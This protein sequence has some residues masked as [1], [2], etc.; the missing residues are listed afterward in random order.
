MDGLFKNIDAEEIEKVLKYLNGRKVAFKKGVTI[1]SNLSNNNEI[2]IILKG[3][4]SL[5]R[6]DYDG[7]R[8]IVSELTTSD[9]FGGCFSDYMTEEMSVVSSSDCEIL[10]VENDLLLGKSKSDFPHK[11]QLIVNVI[12]ILV[13]K[14]SNYNK[15]I[16]VLNKRS[17]REKLLEYFRILESEQA[18]NT[19][20]LPFTFTLLAEYL[21]VDR[22]AMMR[23]IKNLKDEHIIE[24]NSKRITMIIRWKIDLIML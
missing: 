13:K 19:I 11:T 22:S 14:I 12:D 3:R 15:R 1:L 18:S 23:E 16:E 6:I 20:I 10:F 7:I 21:S 24:V 4:A 9:L 8:S 2:G 5:F 17:I